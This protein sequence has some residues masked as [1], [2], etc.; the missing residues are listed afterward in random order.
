M[1][2]TQYQMCKCIRRRTRDHQNKC[3]R[4]GKNVKER[5][6]KRKL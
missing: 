6:G 5:K 2:I 4:E 3:N 1:P